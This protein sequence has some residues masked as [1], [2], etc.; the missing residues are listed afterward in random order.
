M[1]VI[2]DKSK[3][4]ANLLLLFVQKTKTKTLVVLVLLVVFMGKNLVSYFQSPEV[5]PSHEKYHATPEQDEYLETTTRKMVIL[6]MLMV[7]LYIG[8]RR[9]N[10]RQSKEVTETDRDLKDQQPSASPVERKTKSKRD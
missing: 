1:E 10:D 8:L 2:K 7:A 5:E 9:L 4:V 3:W 6:C